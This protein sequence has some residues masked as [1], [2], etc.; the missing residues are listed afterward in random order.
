MII[1][2]FYLFKKVE[3]K[4]R[5]EINYI[6]YME[7]KLNGMRNRISEMKNYHQMGINSTLDNAG[8][9]ISELETI[10]RLFKLA[11]IWREKVKKSINGLW[12]N[13]DTTEYM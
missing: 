9:P 6:I 7:L 1:N 11:Y 13:I 8:K 12:D 3:E 4:T 5:R 2:A 10:V